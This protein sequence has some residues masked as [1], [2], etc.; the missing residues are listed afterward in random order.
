MGLVGGWETSRLVWF[1]SPLSR[2]A[3]RDRL[4][5]VI[6]RVEKLLLLPLCLA[7]V[8]WRGGRE[9]E[10]MVTMSVLMGSRSERR[11]NTC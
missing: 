1:V 9:G 11:L 7:K 3:V 10:A 2:G 4:A 8:G 5:L 6:W